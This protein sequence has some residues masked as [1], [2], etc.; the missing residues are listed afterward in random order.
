[1]DL[2]S[3]VPDRVSIP[4]KLFLSATLL[5]GFANGIFN[6]IGQLYLTSLG[7]DSAALGTIFMM[8]PIGAALLTI[9]AGVL[10]DRY[11]KRKVMLSGF[12]LSGL[13]MILFL[14]GKS[15]EMFMAAFLL[16]GL[17]NASFVVLTPLYASFFDKDDMDKAFGLNGF[18]SII[19][20]SLGS[21][22][23]FVPPMLVARQGFSL[24]YS[25]WTM[26][27]VAV[28]FFTIQMP[29][30]LM[31]LRGVV[32]PENNM[33]FALNLRSKGVV[34]KFCFIAV[35]SN[36]GF[37][38]FF[39]LFPFY[40]NRKFGIQSDALG[41]LFFVSNFVSAGSNA[42]API[43]SKKLGPLKA[44]AAT[45]GLAT[46]FYLMIPLAPNF[47]WL[48]AFYILRRGFATIAD[49]LI[50]SLFMRLLHEEEKATANSIRM[51]ALWGGNI[52]APWL[53]GKL[54]E[55]A[56]LDLPA[57]LGAGLYPVLAASY[58]LLLRN[59]KEVEHAIAA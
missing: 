47:T 2:K 9:P 4:A 45:I 38:V 8:N 30:Y 23:G 44:V 10:A 26:L 20:L 41:T 7:F 29:F 25:Y 39:S 42:I 51:M 56:S 22:M 34:A 57:Y 33:G 15:K 24:S 13:A 50:G 40:V 1:M 16:I 5:N 14:T 27:A 48:S 37:G 12:A 28:G 43:F 49:P 52:G 3:F 35:L 31:S 59:E 58:Y 17:W 54:M 55:H 11:G 36:I 6:V 46:P 18:L 19:A 21:L 53:G 32:E